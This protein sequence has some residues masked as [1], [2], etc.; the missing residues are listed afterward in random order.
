MQRILKLK[1]GTCRQNYNKQ[2]LLVLEYS[3]LLYH[4]GPGINSSCKFAT[5]KKRIKALGEL[6]QGEASRPHKRLPNYTHVY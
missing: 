5:D 2:V 3:E 6:R 4:L 1:T